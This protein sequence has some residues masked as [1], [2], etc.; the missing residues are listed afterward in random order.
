MLSGIRSRPAAI[1]AGCGAFRRH[2]D[3]LREE[4]SAHSDYAPVGAALWIAVGGS[5]GEGRITQRRPSLSPAVACD[6]GGRR[7][8]AYRKRQRYL[9]VVRAFVRQVPAQR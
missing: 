1:R 2:G 5:D 8:K 4:L 6:S 3:L 7:P 9:V